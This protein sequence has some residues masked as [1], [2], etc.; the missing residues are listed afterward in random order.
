[1]VDFISR[2]TRVV[3]L[4]GKRRLGQYIIGDRLG[5]G[6]MAEVYAA[7]YV[8]VNDRLT[9]RALKLILPVWAQQRDIADMFQAEAQLC[10]QLKHP[11]IVSVMDSGEIE[12]ELFMAMEYVDGV[13]CAQLMRILSDQGQSFPLDAA[14]YV[15]VRSLSALAFA[16]NYRNPA[17]KCLGIVHRDVSPGNILFSRGGEVKLTDFGIAI[18]DH[19]SRT[20]SPGE[21]KGK[22]GYMSPEQIAG[23]ELDVRSDLFSLGIVLAE[24][25]IGQRLFVGKN[26]FD[27]LTRMHLAD[28][29]VFESNCSQVPGPIAAVVRKALTRRR[30]D[31][32][33]SA[34]EFLAELL[35]AASASGNP[36]DDTALAR[37][38]FEGGVLPQRSGTHESVQVHVDDA[39]W[40][41]T[42]LP[43]SS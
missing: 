36:I 2:A 7:Q 28:I 31:R 13:S 33:Q 14:L 42:T 1:M 37:C 26:Q 40:D 32:F 3:Q 4:P 10:R 41:P 34:M 43:R 24:M 38:L 27:V 20:T 9:Q 22:C 30:S 23:A 12:G 35:G 25:L 15:T 21:I 19:V 11:S 8:G 5:V 16:H 18:G 39:D 29:R 17:G 6:G